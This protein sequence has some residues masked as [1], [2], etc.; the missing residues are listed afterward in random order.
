MLQAQSLIAQMSQHPPHIREIK[1]AV[2]Q[3]DTSNEIFEDLESSRY[4]DPIGYRQFFTRELSRVNSQR[5]QNAIRKYLSHVGDYTLVV[6][7]E[8]KA[9]SD[10][11]SSEQ[12]LL[13]MKAARSQKIAPY[14]S[15]AKTRADYPK[16]VFPQSIDLSALLSSPSQQ[17]SDGRF[18]CQMKNGMTVTY[19]PI[20]SKK[21]IVLQIRSS[22]G[23][24]TD[25][26]GKEGLRELVQNNLFRGTDRI[27][28]NAFKQ[29]MNFLHAD[30]DADTDIDNF[31]ISFSTL[32]K[33]FLVAAQFFLYTIQH[34]RF[35]DN[36][37]EETKLA[38]N[39]S[40]QITE[41]N[42][43]FIS[44]YIPAF[45]LYPNFAANRLSS[46]TEASIQNISRA[47]LIHYHQQ[48]FDPT[49][50]EVTL[51]GH[52]ANKSDFEKILFLLS[53]I[54]S[55]NH[56]VTF[57]EQQLNT[58]SVY[59]FDVRRV[60]DRSIL[61][62]TGISEDKIEVTYTPRNIDSVYFSQQTLGPS[63]DSWEY[64][65]FHLFRRIL[66]LRLFGR[67][68]DGIKE[69]RDPVKGYLY[70]AEVSEVLRELNQPVLGRYY[71]TCRPDQVKQVL[72]DFNDE[73]LQTVSKHLPT[74]SELMHVIAL[75]RIDW[76]SSLETTSGRMID[77]VNKDHYPYFFR[78]PDGS[79]E[80]VTD[81]REVFRRFSQLSIKDIIEIGGKPFNPKKPF[82]SLKKPFRLHIV[83]KLPE[84]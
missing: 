11:P 53:K 16:V 28:S 64:P 56:Q 33:N 82:T 52:F 21:N 7:Q 75:E 10:F 69:G 41:N 32:D 36:D 65:F 40:R 17:L 14:V 27:S 18:R 50:L 80:S 24:A 8:G 39:G 48:L 9:L 58:P 67:L 66:N 23:N 46:G 6:L 84:K 78:N 29:E 22:L 26:E 72:A 76:L 55:R 61:A 44:R 68:T 42:S 70:H 81:R 5:I 4:V 77:S 13:R 62:A 73:Y 19:L 45:D 79:V 3:E 57:P 2:K 35:G 71:A 12:L 20:E 51:A 59:P 34:P 38:L 60:T 47:D 63:R 83:G 15:D 31:T 37:L 1:D 43:R 30:F 25:P 74:Q 54:P 49:K